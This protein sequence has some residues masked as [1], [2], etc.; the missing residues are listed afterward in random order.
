MTVER[1]IRSLAGFLI[2]LSLVLA[3]DY[4]RLWLLLAAVV[5]VNLFQSGFTNWC[6]AMVLLRKLGFRD[7]QQ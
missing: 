5:G 7:C 1:I 3:I 2:L 6:P 4:S